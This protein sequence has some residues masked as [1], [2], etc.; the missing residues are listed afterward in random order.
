MSSLELDNTQKM[1]L[2]VEGK[3]KITS[4]FS[5]FIFDKKMNFYLILKSL[6][7]KSISPNNLENDFNSA[8]VSICPPP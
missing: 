4:K 2:V 6:Q 7:R 8:L 5:Q 1:S 3:Y